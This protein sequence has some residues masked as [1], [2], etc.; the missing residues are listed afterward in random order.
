MRSQDIVRKLKANGLIGSPPAPIATYLARR[1][2]EELTGSPVADILGPDVTLVPVPR[3]GLSGGKP[4][5]WPG[6]A[7]ADAL[8]LRGF[9]CR[10]E[11]CLRRVRPVPKAAT[12]ARGMRP[13]AADHRDSLAVDNGILFPDGAVLV[14]DVVT[15]GA[16]LM[17]AAW[18]LMDAHPGLSVAAFAAVRTMSDVEIATILAPTT[19]RI[20]L[21]GD[22]TRRRP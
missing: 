7:I 20:A 17:G 14:D 12:A 3:S 16:Q 18:A 4:S 1:M 10:V 11:A 13:T 5:P 8:V 19:G 21:D 15:S 9:G 2:S 22:L 6:Q